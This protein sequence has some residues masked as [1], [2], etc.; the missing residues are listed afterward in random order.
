MKSALRGDSSLL[1]SKP[2]PHRAWWRR[3]PSLG[4]LAL[5]SL[6]LALITGLPLALV[7][8]PAQP[9]ASLQLLQLGNPSG[10]ILRS[11][12]AWTGHLF[13]ICTLLHTLKQ[14]IRRGQMRLRVGPWLRTVA[15]LPLALAVML[16][17]FLLRGDAD[18]QMALQILGGLLERLPGPEL[19]S[20]LLGRGDLG[21]IYTHHIF[22][23]SLP[24][25]IISVEHGRRL[26]PR[27]S[28]LLLIIILSSVL[29]LILP[30]GLHDGLEASRTGPWY[31]LG[32]QE[33]LRWISPPERALLLSLL[34][35]LALAGL[36]KWPQSP[37]ILGGL[38]LS[39]GLYILLSLLIFSRGPSGDLGAEPLPLP[40]RAPRPHRFLDFSSPLEAPPPEQPGYP[41]GCLICHQ[42]VEGFSPAHQGLGC[43]ICHLGDPLSLD[44]ERAHDGL[45]RVPGN[46]D[47]AHLTCGRCHPELLARVQQSLMATG[48]GMVAVDRFIFG[49]QAQ[50]DGVV[51]LAELGESPADRHLQQLCAGCHLNKPKLKPAPL[52]ERSRGGGCVACHLQDLQPRRPFEA[53]E[54]YTHPRLSAAVTDAH[55]FGC[56]SRSGRISLSYQGLGETLLKPEEAEEEMRILEDGRVLAPLPPDV[57]H[58]QG[59]SCVDCHTAR[60]TMGDGRLY[61][62][63]EKAVEIECQDCHPLEPPKLLAPEALDPETRSLLRLRGQTLG[64]APYVQTRRSERPLNNVRW[65][66]GR[67]RVDSKSTTDQVWW[68]SPP[69]KACRAAHH[70]RLSCRSCHSAWSHHCVSCHTRFDP[71]GESRDAV[72]GAKRQGRFLE[73]RDAPR[74]EAPTLGLL[75]EERIVPF[76]PG[77]IMDLETGERHLRWRLYAPVAPHTTSRRGRACQSCHLNPLALGFGRGRLSFEEGRW[78]FE[79]ELALREDGLP[80]DA[81]TGFLIAR[82]KP[83]STRIDARPLDPEVQGRV[84]QVGR[85]LSCHTGEETLFER[86]SQSLERCSPECRGEK[87]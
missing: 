42:G 59:M 31:F 43:A 1:R 62:H 17:G 79:P 38:S 19:H 65:V 81:W 35:L 45:V 53:K 44:P 48:R 14:L 25:W 52:S 15:L 77:M 32:L 7:Y 80:A 4:H 82:E 12:H 58:R 23:A 29:G 39:L 69:P 70:Q 66:Q 49:E 27:A 33:A 50:P 24:L 5:A 84:L 34:L 61:L 74:F 78:R 54:P 72:T 11:L 85:C 30:P 8:D 9:L 63:Q 73:L 60:D 10:R 40:S 3:G 83:N 57:H 28:A 51:S 64:E 86:F 75:G 36:R 6:L 18:A 71:Q 46:L 37:L 67:L 41:E 16:T 13:L 21:V 2:R 22:S 20:S 26:W 56:H 47:S 55:C 76:A 68:P 87:D